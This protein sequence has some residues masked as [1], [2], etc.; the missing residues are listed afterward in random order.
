M[1]KLINILLVFALASCSKESETSLGQGQVT[2]ESETI[3]LT[4][5]D[6]DG[7]YQIDESLIPEASLFDLTITGTDTNLYYASL[8]DYDSPLL[9]KGIYKAVISSGDNTIESAISPCFEGSCNFTVI[10]RTS[11]LVTISASLSNSIISFDCSEMFDNY[12]TD[13][14]LTITTQSGTEF[15]FTQN[16]DPNDIFFVKEGSTLKINGSAKK[17]GNGTEVTFN[18]AVLDVTTKAQTLHSI[19]L[20]VEETVGGTIL[21]VSIDNTLTEI[22]EINIQVNTEA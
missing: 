14:T 15:S 22:D 2:F 3:A 8:D 21:K 9:N 20:E 5:T 12:Y 17:V 6:N 7:T 10:E 19:T 13:Y 1:K 18:E 16:S 11:Y 4:K